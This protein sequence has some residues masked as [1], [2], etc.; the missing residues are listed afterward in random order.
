MVNTPALILVVNPV[1]K[2]VTV[3]L[4]ASPPKL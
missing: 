2:P 1:G 4:V 3:A